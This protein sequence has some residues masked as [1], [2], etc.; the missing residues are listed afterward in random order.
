MPWFSFRLV[1]TVARNGFLA[2]KG[3]GG[4]GDERSPVTGG[5][6][7]HLGQGLVGV[8]QGSSVE[9]RGGVGLPVLTRRCGS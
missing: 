7:L 8:G 5:F 4:G 1:V 3:L 2:S 9:S 6:H